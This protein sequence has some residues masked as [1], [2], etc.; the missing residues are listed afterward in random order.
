[1]IIMMIMIK[2]PCWAHGFFFFRW[3]R[4]NSARC[5]SAKS[6]SNSR[7]LKSCPRVSQ[8]KSKLPSFF[9]QDFSNLIILPNWAVIKTLISVLAALFFFVPKTDFWKSPF[10]ASKSRTL[11]KG[12]NPLQRGS[13]PS[14]SI[15]VGPRAARGFDAR[16]NGP[17]QWAHWARAHLALAER[18]P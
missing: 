5:Q 4:F 12:Q 11:F 15:Q 18:F 9:S 3:G 7:A 1:M 2:R 17:G 8:K 16:Q 10:L 6:E 14:L 13:P